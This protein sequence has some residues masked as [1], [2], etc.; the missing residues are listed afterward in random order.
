VGPFSRYGFW[1]MMDEARA[2]FDMLL[3]ALYLLIAAPAHRRW[4]PSSPA[5][6]GITIWGRNKP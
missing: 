5:T 2:D 4:T 1:S 3:G 6:P